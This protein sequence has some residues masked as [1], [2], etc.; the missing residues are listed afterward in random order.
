[1]GLYYQTLLSLLLY[2]AFSKAENCFV[3][4]NIIENEKEFADISFSAV[5]E[6]NDSIEIYGNTALI[7]NCKT[8]NYRFKHFCSISSG[9]W[10][11]NPGSKSCS[12]IKTCSAL[13]EN[14][15]HW[16]C[17]NFFYSGSVCHGICNHDQDL[18]ISKKCSSSGAWNF[19]NGN[20]NTEKSC[21]KIAEKCSQGLQMINQGKF[22]FV[23]TEK[24]FTEA[25]KSCNEIQGFKLF[26]PK[27]LATNDQVYEKGQII[28][29]ND[30]FW[31]WIGIHDRY[32]ESK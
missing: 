24:N 27:D 23:T 4:K 12:S 29:D 7:M 25:I 9:L 31:A 3:D 30:R 17:N 20:E 14:P 26:E 21:L 6:T 5:K 22:C 15:W 18:K 1:M 10:D 16:N 13:T 2:Q 32:N 11:S 8:S 28:F 19:Q